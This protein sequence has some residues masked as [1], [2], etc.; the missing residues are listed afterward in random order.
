VCNTER[1]VC[2]TLVEEDQS[3]D[4]YHVCPAPLACIKTSASFFVFD[5]VCV[6]PDATVTCPDGITVCPVAQFCGS[7]D[8]GASYV[9]L[10]RHA[11]GEPCTQDVGD[12][13]GNGC[14]AALFCNALGVCAKDGAVDALCNQPTACEPGAYCTNGFACAARIAAGGNC[15]PNGGIDVGCAEGAFCN[16]E[17]SRC[18]PTGS[19]G[20]SCPAVGVPF[21]QDW[22][23]PAWDPCR[24]S[25]CVQ[26]T[27]AGNYVPCAPPCQNG[28]QCERLVPQGVCR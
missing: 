6:R 10:P 19:P 4:L 14:A 21:P 18:E 25:T 27:C 11:L 1:G 2:A 15:V 12:L 24:D 5:G 23:D 17:T 7:N 13:N 8:A 16:P 22:P 9:C 20:Q 26:G 28:E 3:C